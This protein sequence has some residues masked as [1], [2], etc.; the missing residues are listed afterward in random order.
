MWDWSVIQ[1]GI[2]VAQALDSGYGPTSSLDRSV[3]ENGEVLTLKY[4]GQEAYKGV[5]D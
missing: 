4:D 3:P 1:T 5:D 2:E